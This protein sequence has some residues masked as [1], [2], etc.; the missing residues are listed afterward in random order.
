MSTKLKNYSTTIPAQKTVTEIMNLLIEL[1]A[2]NFGIVKDNGIISAISFTLEVRSFHL[3]FRVDARPNGV[4]RVL[5]E[6]GAERRFLTNSHCRDVA[7]RIVRDW[8]AITIATVQIGAIEPAEAFMGFMLAPK[9][10]AT[11]YEEFMSTQ[12]LG[13]GETA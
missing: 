13:P 8:I 9:S 4:N 10:N 5:Q 2:V 1:G 3:S 6:Q 7:W 11:F 12:L